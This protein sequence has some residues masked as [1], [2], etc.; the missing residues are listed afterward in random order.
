VVYGVVTEICVR[1]AAF[2]LL[3]AGVRVELVTDGV[4]SLDDAASAEMMR[5][6][7]NGG[8]VLTTVNEVCRS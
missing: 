5:E 3:N 2:G 8:G 4:R 7:T 1:C 6:F